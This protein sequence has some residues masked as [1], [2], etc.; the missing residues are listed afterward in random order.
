MLAINYPENQ[1]I[2]EYVNSYFENLIRMSSTVSNN[3]K[4]YCEGILASHKKSMRG[5]KR[6]LNLKIHTSNISRSIGKFPK[7]VTN[8][9]LAIYNGIEKFIDR[10]SNYYVSVDD[11]HLTKY[12]KYVYGTSYQYDSTLGSMLWCNT[13]VDSV[14]SSK[15]GGLF[16]SE[17]TLYLKKFFES[18]KTYKRQKAC[19]C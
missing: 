15:K 10:R 17:C 2:Y 18:N 6:A 19:F 12:G 13:L 8:A 9:K 16:L 14:V 1:T 11:T 4:Q 3:L 5:I 7:Y